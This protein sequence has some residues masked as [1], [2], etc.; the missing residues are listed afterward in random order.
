MRIALLSDIHGN[1][2][3]LDAVLA[4]IERQG[5]V[6]AFWV[7]GD[8]AALGHDPV[9]VLER[10]ATLPHARFVRGNTDRYVVTGDRP[11]PSLADAR[12][13][14][15]LL[16]ALVDIAGSFAWTQGMV[17][18]S[19]WL[20]WLADLPLELRETLPD[21][22]RFLGVHAAPGTDDGPGISPD[23]GETELGE[24]LS[25]CE[26][27]LICVGHTHWPLETRVDG[28][29]VVNLGSVSNP[30]PPDLRACYV[31]LRA[32]ESGYSLEHRR[33][34]YDREA[35][36]AAVQRLRHPGAEFIIRHMRG[37]RRPRWSRV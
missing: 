22:V 36:I 7:L 29:R 3:A 18:A 19:G 14:P 25:G 35:V 23:I 15:E 2:M 17:T 16:P 5:G 31:V 33:V 34:D 9:G 12:G 1:S 6:D 21:G 32:D 8:L 37:E 24:R 20:E 28:R 10:L 30:L 13:N 27:E 4:D 11:P 26:A